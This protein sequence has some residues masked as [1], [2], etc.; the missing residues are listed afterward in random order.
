MEELLSMQNESISALS[1]G[2]LKAILQ[3][4]HVRIPQD[5]LEKR[6]IVERV[7]TLV[8]AARAG[9]E[10]EARARAA[11]E[12]AEL[13]AQ[14]HALE[15]I[16]RRKNAAIQRSNVDAP[17]EQVHNEEGERRLGSPRISLVPILL[18]KATL[19]CQKRLSPPSPNSNE[20]DYV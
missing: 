6:D 10:R 19:P 17:E 5:A 9:K 7:V 20:M 15:E 12:E 16:E 18:Y 11:E 1:V 8:E 4:N 14:R 2:A 3:H 13:E